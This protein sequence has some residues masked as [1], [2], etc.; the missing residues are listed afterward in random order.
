MDLFYSSQVNFINSNSYYDYLVIKTYQ[1][2]PTNFTNQVNF[3]N[4][5]LHKLL[6]VAYM[7]SSQK[8]WQV[9]E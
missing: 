6:S 1:I 2:V 9:I 4:A 3:N 8:G 7:P 5:D